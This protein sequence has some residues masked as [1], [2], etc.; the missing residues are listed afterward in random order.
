MSTQTT[1]QL[2]ATTTSADVE[3]GSRAVDRA[4]DLR[5]RARAFASAS[6]SEATLAAYASDL[7]HFSAWA[8]TNGRAAVP[9][10]PETV[11]LY[12]TSMVDDFKPSTLSRRDRA[13]AGPDGRAEARWAHE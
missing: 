3:L 9:A 12:L 11:A 8:D 6:R 5:D 2:P 4:A 7:R 13:T 10:D 1:S